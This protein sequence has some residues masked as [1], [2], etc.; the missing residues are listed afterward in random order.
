MK[1]CFGNELKQISKQK[2]TNTNPDTCTRQT[3][4]I[5]LINVR[6]ISLY[7]LY[8]SWTSSDMW[9]LRP[10]KWVQWD[11]QDQR[12]IQSV[13][14]YKQ[15]GLILPETLGTL[16]TFRV[17]LIWERKW[18]RKRTAEMQAQHH[19]CKKKRTQSGFGLHGFF[20]RQSQPMSQITFPYSPFVSL[21]FL[22]SHSR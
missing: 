8:L 15:R 3:L 7:I 12:S 17:T 13:K 2:K 11:L 14:L 9:S 18:Q 6:D 22:L 16:R 10:V 20:K 19:I 1:C 21:N 4:N 5:Y